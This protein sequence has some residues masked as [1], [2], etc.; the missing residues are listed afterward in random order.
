VIPVYL[1]GLWGHTSSLKAGKAFRSFPRLRHV[2]TIVVGEPRFTAS[3]ATMRE[4]ILELGTQA[5]VERKDSTA[6]LTQRFVKQ[7]RRNWP[8]K[9]IADSTGRSLSY[10]EA[11]VDSLLLSQWIRSNTR[12]SRTIGVLSPASLDGALAN[13]AIT[14]AGKT[15]VNLN[16]TAGPDQIRQAVAISEIT[17]ILA[18]RELAGKAALDAVR[19]VVID[20]V[21][22]MFTSSRRVLTSI[23]ARFL[24]AAVLA[25]GALP[26]NAAAVIFSSGSTGTPKGAMLSHWNLVSNTDASARIYPVRRGDC[27]LGV[28]PFFHSFGYAYTL[29]FPLLNGFH[30]V[31]H[32]NPTDANVIGELAAKHRPAFFLSTPTFC[33]AYLRRCTREQFA[34]IRC[35]VVG[36]EKLRPSLASAF[37]EKFGITLLEGYGCTEMGPVVSAN[38]PQSGGGGSVGRPLPNVSMKIVDPETFA[39]LEFGETGLLLVNGPGRMTGYAKD[40]ARTAQSLHEGYYVTGDLAFVD[41]DGF[42]HIVDRLARFSK[43]AGEMVSHGKIE[44]VLMEV[45]G[46]G[47]VAV[48]GVPDERRGER[49]VV[50]Y[51]A[52]QVS[53]EDMIEHLRQSGLPALWIPKRDN[54]SRIESV[55]MLGSGKTDLKRVREMATEA[56][57]Q[58]AIS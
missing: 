27:I 20:E 30:A 46:A 2:V 16:Y 29:W 37:E 49:L 44:E 6:T 58:E 15:A 39:P 45:T 23:A 8:A 18:T 11:L 9:A 56:V 26:D 42:L 22:S 34:G 50:L 10:G 1:D 21:R 52:D 41:G 24:P 43:I 12:E 4:H 19:V 53:P 51:T 54:F 55:P 47:R 36:A 17:M 25:P 14:L 33:M 40:A 38:V 28:L 31:Y 3:A 57:M 7:A 32:A 13:L 35:F 48:T 5:A